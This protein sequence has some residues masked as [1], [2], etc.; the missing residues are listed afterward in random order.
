MNPKKEIKLKKDLILIKIWEIINRMVERKKIENLKIKE[1]YDKNKNYFDPLENKENLNL[2]FSLDFNDFIREICIKSEAKNKNKESL[3]FID[4]VINMED[5]LVLSYQDKPEFNK[6]LELD[7]IIT[8][9]KIKLGERF[10]SYFEDFGLIN[11][12][13]R[14]GSRYII[15]DNLDA[16]TSQNLKSLDFNENLIQEN[17]DN[18]T[19]VLPTNLPMI[20]QPNKWSDTQFGGYLNNKIEKN[21]LISGL[22]T[23]NSHKVKSLKNLYN[24]VN[25]LSSIKFRVNTEL[26]DYILINKDIIFKDY[27]N[28]VNKEKLKDKIL[29]DVVTLEIAKTFLNIPFYL[30]TFAD[31][32]GRIYTHSYYLSYQSSDLSLALLQFDEGQIITEKG[33]Y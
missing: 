8:T 15:L 20:C 11:E 10:I 16:E 4:K 24:A 22:G 1:Y 29:R 13:W 12:T 21:D 28:T 30:N 25:Y 6:K 7:L 31:W 17:I 14:D 26:L 18:L 19:N 9:F 5:S 23:N 32:R 2:D 27:Y 33:L 3:I